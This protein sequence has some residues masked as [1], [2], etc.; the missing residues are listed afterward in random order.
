MVVEKWTYLAMEFENRKETK[1]K[2][3]FLKR[4]ILSERGSIFEKTKIKVMAIGF[5]YLDAYGSEDLQMDEINSWFDKAKSEIIEE[6]NDTVSEQ[7]E[8]GSK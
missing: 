3:D 6:L 5:H 4:I 8:G 2:A 1:D 7:D